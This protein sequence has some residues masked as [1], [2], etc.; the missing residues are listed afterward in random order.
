MSSISWLTD[1]SS[2]TTAIAIVSRCGGLPAPII[3]ESSSR[4]GERYGSHDGDRDQERQRE[5]DRRSRPSEQLQN[6][7]LRNLGEKRAHHAW[8]DHQ[9]DD[10]S[11]ERHADQRLEVED[12]EQRHA[13]RAEKHYPEPGQHGACCMALFTI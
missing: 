2:L 3:G 12:G 11:G 9:G 5:H 4:N 13:A 6:G 10:E 8:K 7:R 1:A